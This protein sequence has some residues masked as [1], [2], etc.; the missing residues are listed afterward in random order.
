MSR[1]TRK[2]MRRLR[3][4][5]RSPRARYL[6]LTTVAAFLAERLT[7]TAASAGWRRFYGEDPPRNPERLDVTWGQALTWT[8]LTGL[9][10]TL[11]G[12]LARRGTAIGW[13]HF[14]HRPLPSR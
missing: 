11:A 13:R 1:N 9:S 6:L 14:T 12:L 7:R 5:A 2:L 10:M 3:K 4:Q 8:A